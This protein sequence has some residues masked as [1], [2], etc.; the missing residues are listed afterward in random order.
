MTPE[1]APAA[2]EDHKWILVTSSLPAS[3]LS[4]VRIGSKNP[5]REPFRAIWYT[6]CVRTVSSAV[7]RGSST[8]DSCTETA[9]TAF[10]AFGLRRLLQDVPRVGVLPRRALGPQLAVELQSSL[11]DLRGVRKLAREHASVFH[12]A[13]EGTGRTVTATHAPSAPLTKPSN[14]LSR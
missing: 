13:D 1:D 4:R 14:V 6:Y 10:Q 2:M 8:T 7:P 3:R 9:L 11:C 5:S 12:R